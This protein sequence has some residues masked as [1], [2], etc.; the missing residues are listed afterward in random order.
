[1]SNVLLDTRKYLNMARPP[2]SEDRVKRIIL[3]ALIIGC[4]LVGMSPDR[5]NS[6]SAA[7]SQAGTQN[8]KISG[9]SSGGPVRT[10]CKSEIDKHCAGESEAG[11][12]L[13]GLRSD[14]L[15]EQCKAALASRG[16]R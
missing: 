6:Q 16:S 3:G 1:M 14:E 7:E 2:N 4:V 11:R 8:N 15:S 5:A 10:A 13:R 9:G 12:C